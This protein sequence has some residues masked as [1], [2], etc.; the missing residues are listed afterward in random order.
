[1]QA[2]YKYLH[3]KKNEIDFFSLPSI[4]Y[5]S[6]SILD[7]FGNE[8]GTLSMASLCT[9]IQCIE[10]PGPVYNF[11]WQIWHLKCFAFWCCMSI[12]SSSNSRLQYLNLVKANTRLKINRLK[13]LNIA[14]HHCSVCVCAR[15]FD[16]E[17]KRIPAPWFR[18]LL[19]FT[20]HFI[21]T[22]TKLIN[23]YTITDYQVNAV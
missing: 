4:P 6:I 1:M 14:A 12:F 19:L 5:I 20:T 7:L 15:S 11:L 21:Y 22:V 10:S 3:T 18:L 13:L 16:S 17:R 9:C 23:N 8:F 2:I